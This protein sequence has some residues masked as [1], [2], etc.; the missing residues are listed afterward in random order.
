MLQF[1]TNQYRLGH[2]LLLMTINKTS[3][4]S[5]YRW[6]STTTCTCIINITQLIDIGCQR[7]AISLMGYPKVHTTPCILGC[8][9]IST[10]VGWEWSTIIM[11]KL[12]FVTIACNSLSRFKTSV[13]HSFHFLVRAACTQVFIDIFIYFYNTCELVRVGFCKLWM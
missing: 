3:H 2:L 1:A 5:S 12:P 4:K 13:W 10:V 9:F 7:S 11:G 8:T 6:S